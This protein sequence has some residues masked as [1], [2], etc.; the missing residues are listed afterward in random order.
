[1]E[2]IICFHCLRVIETKYRQTL[3]GFRAYT[4]QECGLRSVYPLPVL[5]HQI[6][7][8]V[9]LI[10]GTMTFFSLVRGHIAFPGLLCIAGII[11]LINNRNIKQQVKAA[12]AAFLQSRQQNTPAE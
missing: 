12:Y 8:G 5:Y 9:I 2:P 1:M 11:S 7:R 6:Y 3:L 4:C 10:G